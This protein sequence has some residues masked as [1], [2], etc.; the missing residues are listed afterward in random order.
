ME[1]YNHPIWEELLK[2]ETVQEQRFGQ[3]TKE[4]QSAEQ[5]K[6]RMDSERR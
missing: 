6:C 3:F 1:N 2:F 4:Q 5:K